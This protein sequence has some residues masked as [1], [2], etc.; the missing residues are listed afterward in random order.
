MTH[1]GYCR[2]S[3]RAEDHQEQH[4]GGKAE[5]GRRALALGRSGGGEDPDG[6]RD[7][8]PRPAH[9]AFALA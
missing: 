6:D 3:Q 2:R 8:E 4:E 7:R 9:L 5:H 1:D